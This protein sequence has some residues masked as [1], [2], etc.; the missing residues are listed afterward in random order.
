MRNDKNASIAMLTNKF[1]TGKGTRLPYA[2]LMIKEKPLTEDRSC[3]C[4]KKNK[5]IST[6]NIIIPLM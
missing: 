4:I 6:Q 3:K 5:K 2:F 1:M